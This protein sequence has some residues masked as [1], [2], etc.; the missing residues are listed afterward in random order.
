MLVLLSPEVCDALSLTIWVSVYGP[1]LNRH[2]QKWYLFYGWLS[3][4]EEE[5]EKEEEEE[6]KEE[7][8]GTVESERERAREIDR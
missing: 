3:Q 4:E 7:D 2:Y 5:E 1:A 6:E 8:E